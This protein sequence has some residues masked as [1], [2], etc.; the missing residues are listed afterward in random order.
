MIPKTEVILLDISLLSVAFKVSC[1]EANVLGSFVQRLYGQHVCCL[2][3]SFLDPRTL[4]PN[5]SAHI[6]SHVP[7][8]L[9]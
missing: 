2:S 4:D 9:T 1:L 6:K 8:L 3:A 5:V 7:R